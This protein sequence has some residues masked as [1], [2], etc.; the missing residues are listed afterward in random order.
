MA[1][2]LIPGLLA[3]AFVIGLRVAIRSVIRLRVIP[4]EVV[5]TLGIL[6]GVVTSIVVPHVSGA[7]TGEGA[8]H[9]A[10]SSH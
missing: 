10:I 9:A 4:P 5:L 6:F 2:A 7:L 3:L 1:S 8:Q